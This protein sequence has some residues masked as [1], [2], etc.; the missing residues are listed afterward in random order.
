M[1]KLKQ[2]KGAGVIDYVMLVALISVVSIGAVSSVRHSVA[3]GFCELIGGVDRNV[4]ATYVRDPNTG[5]GTCEKL[6][7][8]F[9]GQASLYF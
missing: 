8:M 3:K 4:D 5:Q 6:P 1:Y 2:E 9:G 7:G